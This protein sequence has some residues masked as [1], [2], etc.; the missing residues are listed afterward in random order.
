M[1]TSRPSMR[2]KDTKWYIGG[3]RLLDRPVSPGFGNVDW[4]E[5]NVEFPTKKSA[6]TH[7]KERQKAMNKRGKV[8]Y[9]TLYSK[10]YE[11]FYD[12]IPLYSKVK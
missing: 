2:T 11:Q 6:M 5:T 8:G 9:F 4:F 3:Y 7:I 12:G 1:I 10:T